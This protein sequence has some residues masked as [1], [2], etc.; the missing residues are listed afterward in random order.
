MNFLFALLSLPLL[1]P[2]CN[3]PFDSTAARQVEFWG[4]IRLEGRP[5]FEHMAVLV[6]PGLLPFGGAPYDGGHL[7]LDTKPF[8]D[9]EGPCAMPPIRP[10]ESCGFSNLAQHQHV[11]QDLSMQANHASKPPNQAATQP[12][13]HIAPCGLPCNE[14]ITT[15]PWD[16]QRE[17]EQSKQ[18]YP[19]DLT[20]RN[21]ET[22]VL[23]CRK[24]PW[25]GRN[26]QGAMWLSPTAASPATNAATSVA[27][28]GQWIPSR[29]DTLSPGDS[30][31]MGDLRPP[32]GSNCLALPA[33]TTNDSLGLNYRLAW[34]GT[35]C[36]SSGD[37][38][39]IPHGLSKATRP[40]SV[41]PFQGLPVRVPFLPLISP[42][43]H[44]AWVWTPMDWS[45]VVGAFV[46]FS[47]HRHPHARK[48]WFFC[49]IGVLIA[50]AIIW[51]L[52]TL[53]TIL[54]T[55]NHSFPQLGG[56]FGI[57]R[58]YWTSSVGCAS[59]PYA[60]T[61]LQAIHGT[62]RTGHTYPPHTRHAG[63]S[64][65]L[66]RPR[67]AMKSQESEARHEE[68]GDLAHT[69]L[70]LKCRDAQHN[71]THHLKRWG[72][73]AKITRQ[74]RRQVWNLS[75]KTNQARQSFNRL[76]D[77]SNIHRNIASAP[78]TT[79]RHRVVAAV[80]WWERAAQRGGGEEKNKHNNEYDASAVH[81]ARI[82]MQHVQQYRF[83]P[84]DCLFDSLE[85]LTGIPSLTIRQ[86]AVSHFRS[87]LA[88]GQPNAVHFAAEIMNSPHTHGLQ[89]I[90]MNTYFQ[91]MS[92]SAADGGMWADIPILTYAG[93]ATNTAIHYYR[94]RRSALD[95]TTHLET[96]PGL[97]GYGSKAPNAPHHNLL[98]TGSDL[99]GHYTPL[100]PLN[101]L[102]L[103]LGRSPLSYKAPPMAN[104]AIQSLTTTNATL[105]QHTEE[106]LLQAAKKVALSLIWGMEGS[107]DKTLTRII[108]DTLS[109]HGA[110]RIAL[111]DFPSIIV[112]MRVHLLGCQTFRAALATLD[113]P[114]IRRTGGEV[115]ADFGDDDDDDPPLPQANAPLAHV[116]RPMATGTQGTAAAAPPPHGKTAPVK[117]PTRPGHAAQPRLRPGQSGPKL[118]IAKSPPGPKRLVAPLAPAN[119]TDME[120]ETTSL[121]TPS[122][123]RED[124]CR[125]APEAAI[126][127]PPG[128]KNPPPGNLQVQTSKLKA[129]GT[130]KRLLEK[131]KAYWASW[132]T[133]SAQLEG[134]GKN[135]K[136][137]TAKAKEKHTDMGN[138]QAGTAKVHTLESAW[139]KPSPPLPTPPVTDPDLPQAAN[140]PADPAAHLAP[141]RWP[142]ALTL[143]CM[144]LLSHSSVIS[145]TLCDLLPAIAVL[146]E[147]KL[148]TQL[149]HNSTGKY[150]R[151]NILP[152]YITHFSS[153]SR[154]GVARPAGKAGVA[155]CISSTHASPGSV[156][157]INTKATYR[158]RGYVC[159]C[160][161]TRNSPY[162]QTTANIIGVYFPE[163][164][165]TRRDIYQYIESVAETC[166]K[167]G[168]PLLVAG[169]WN[170]VLLPTDR[171]GPLDAAD[172]LHAE[173]C[174]NIGL[175]PLGS[176]PSP[177]RAHTFNR[178]QL[179]TNAP[180]CTSRIDDILYL[181]DRNPPYIDAHSETV[182]E[183]GGTL[184]HLA[185]LIPIPPAI[186]SL[187]WG[188][189][190]DGHPKT[191]EG[192]KLRFPIKKEEL[193]STKDKIMAT[194]DP[195]PLR[196]AIR[197]VLDKLLEAL[198]GN[199]TSAN[200]IATRKRLQE[201]GAL[202]EVDSLANS[203]QYLLDKA[204]DIMLKTCRTKTPHSRL[205]FRNRPGRTFRRLLLETRAMKRFLAATATPR[206]V[207]NERT[208]DHFEDERKLLMKTC[209]NLTSHDQPT[210]YVGNGT[211]S[212][213]ALK[214]L[215]SE[216][217]TLLQETLHRMTDM[218]RDKDQR[219]R[220]AT[221]VAFQAKIATQRK[222]ANRTIF[223]D[224]MTD[225][226]PAAAHPEIQPLEA[227][228]DPV[229][230]KIATAPDKV[231][232]IMQEYAKCLLAPTYI[233]KDGSYLPEDRPPGF[234]YPFNDPNL[235]DNFVLDRMNAAPGAA[236][237]DTEADLLELL[238]TRGTYEDRL[239]HLGRGKM[240]G[241][242]KIPNELLKTLPDPWHDLIHDLF[243][244]MWIT[245]KTPD[246][247]KESNTILLYK[248]GDTFAPM[249]YRPIGLSNAL[250]KFWTSN[251]TYVTMHHALKNNI[252]HKCQEGGV[253]CR[254]T[255]RQLRTLINAF[256]D[257]FEHKRDLYCLYVDFSSAFNMVMHDKLLCTMYDLGIPPDAIEV[258]RDI[259]S[260]HRTTIHLPIGHTDP[261][262]LTRGT[263]Q[264]DPL[265]PLLFLLYIEPLLRWLHVGG[266]GYEFGSIPN[267]A[268]DEAGHYLKDIHNL[269]A[270]GFVDD[271]SALTGTRANMDT[272]ALK[273]EKYSAWAGTPVNASKCAV[274]AILHG[275]AAMQGGS[276]ADP[277][278][279]SRLLDHGASVHVDGRP[280]PY[281]P[282]DKPYKYLGVWLCP[283]KNWEHQISETLANITT[284]GRQLAASMASPRQCLE[285]IMT[286]IKPVITYPFCIS[287][288]T[289]QDIH[290]FDRCLAGIVRKCLRLPRSFPTASIL[291]S[292]TQGG[293]GL[294]S[295][296]VDYVADSG[297]YLVRATSDPGR[298]GHTSLALLKSQRESLGGAPV[299]EIPT[300]AA[301]YC[302]GLRQLALMA[303]NG[304]LFTING[305]PFSETPHS[306]AEHG[307]LCALLRFPGVTAPMMS[308]LHALGVRHL[309]NLVNTNGTQVITPTDLANIYGD[310]VKHRHKVA[311]NQISVALSGVS[312]DP[313][314]PAKIR[315]TETLPAQCRTLPPDLCM[316]NR[317]GGRTLIGTMNIRTLFAR[318]N[319]PSAPTHP[320][321]PPAAVV[322]AEAAHPQPEVSRR[323]RRSVK[324]QRLY[325]QNQTHSSYNTE[326]VFVS[327]ET[328]SPD[329]VSADNPG[330]LATYWQNCQA[331]AATMPTKVNSTYWQNLARNSASSW[332]DFRQAVCSPNHP[333]LPIALIAN[334]YNHQLNIT[335]VVGM[336]THRHGGRSHRNYEVSWANTMMCRHHFDACS[337]AY[338]H[339]GSITRAV[340][341]GDLDTPQ[342]VATHG[343]F[344]M[345]GTG[346]TLGPLDL[347]MVISSWSDT[348]DS[349]LHLEASHS[350]FA[351]LVTTFEG[352]IHNKPKPAAKGP[353]PP[354]DSHTNLPSHLQQGISDKL[355]SLNLP[356][357][358]TRQVRQSVHLNSRECDP[359]HD[360]TPPGQHT[361]QTGV[362]RAGESD[363][364]ASASNRENVYLPDGR[365]VGSV[366]SK[367][368]AN[369]QSM[370][371]HTKTTT[372]EVHERLGGSTFP[373]DVAQLLLRWRTRKP[374]TTAGEPPHSCGQQ[375]ARATP[376]K[377][378]A[379]LRDALGITLERFASPMDR[380][381]HSEAYWSPFP[382]DALFGS[383]HDA[384]SVPWTGA[385]QAYVGENH[386]ECEKAI[387]WAIHS[388]MSN[389]STPT[390]TILIL[391]HDPR[392]PHSRHL[393]HPATR[394]IGLLSGS[395]QPPDCQFSH[396]KSWDGRPPPDRRP[397]MPMMAMI[398]ISNPAG[399]TTFLSPSALCQLEATWA[400]LKVPE[401]IPAMDPTYMFRGPRALIRIQ[402]EASTDA[403]VV[404]RVPPPLTATHCPLPRQGP[405]PPPRP[406]TLPLCGPSPEGRGSTVVAYTD[407]SCIK[408]GITHKTGAAVYFPHIDLTIK[409]NPRGDGPSNTINRAELSALHNGIISNT[410]SEADA[411]HLYT[412]SACSISL[413]SRIIN[414][415]WSLGECIHLD[416]LRN[417]AEALRS[418]AERGQTTHVHKVRAHSGVKFNDVVDEK[419]KSAAKNPDDADVTET[420]NNTPYDS[421]PWIAHMKVDEDNA[422]AKPRLTFVSSLTI[423]TKT[424]LT[425]ALSGGGPV[426]GVYAQAWAATIPSLNP[427]SISQIWTDNHITWV[428]AIYTL[429]ARWGQLFNQKLAFRYG[430]APNPN[431]LRCGQPDSVGHMLGGCQEKSCKAITIERHNKSV[432][433]ITDTITRSSKFGGCFTVMD[434]CP[435]TQLPPGVQATRLPPWL[436]PRGH[437]AAAELTRCRPDV[438]IVEGL[439]ACLLAGKSDDQIR[440]LLKARQTSIHILEVGF[441]SDT[442]HADKESDKREQHARLLQILTQPYT[443]T[444]EATQM[445]PGNEPYTC[446]GRP[447]RRTAPFAQRA[448][449]YHPPMTIGRTGSLP[450]TL[451]E[452][453][454][455]PLQI[456]PHAANTCAAALT[457]HAVHYVERMYKNRYH[458]EGTA[459]AHAAG[460]LAE[461]G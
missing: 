141:E 203:L 110:A 79:P 108:K 427:H 194:L 41:H 193:L 46:T 214:H 129:V 57:G 20:D 408:D 410:A 260:D 4:E 42:P 402:D 54:H 450:S 438:L 28:S 454:K 3:C 63:D 24:K 10:S 378:W 73:Q 39:W 96:S 319:P 289:M 82:G 423:G 387:R 445:D 207:G 460:P 391:P 409:I 27:A 325:V 5:S 395:D 256:D 70:S 326:E 133:K 453:L 380:S 135:S 340:L 372:P 406:C 222:S 250:Y 284:K 31:R 439:P 298:L 187:P 202:P 279:L 18:L 147:T 414:A 286:C 270:L 137:N 173:Y 422:L 255:H 219:Q 111:L 241:P 158:L 377:L 456:S 321:P 230:G 451:T 359:D 352:R 114:L 248:K 371:T 238:M 143:N 165:D 300:G 411:L 92:V 176:G 113:G 307:W 434:A 126:P 458:P 106:Q 388:A 351:A 435:S 212:P 62:N 97:G 274:T 64:K 379:A 61:I 218:R 156:S 381:T 303:R 56:I 208:S 368:L 364:D 215:R 66:Q 195:Y 167:S 242:D 168:Q 90:D 373:K 285:I 349:E 186:L 125:T 153:L 431:C 237:P 315:T 52:P 196:A 17:H 312:P 217:N 142:T 26:A 93:M 261:I 302:T 426:G 432:R 67:G 192:P 421:R 123:N 205:C 177:N 1:L 384:Y 389:T 316:P 347:D 415:P 131:A 166:H 459:G 71:Q 6:G 72:Q 433:I 189:P 190:T 103:A 162:V 280:I 150:I 37:T 171:T 394:I 263:I 16:Y 272:Q 38:R 383:N 124:P 148:N 452:T 330:L 200:I 209:P 264:G 7:V 243:I 249:N 139:S 210:E 420:S 104:S 231:V 35:R 304:L 295:L 266:R 370:W 323:Q 425:A 146:T 314:N 47:L 107:T 448:V 375:P 324:A 182:V 259:Y 23:R 277:T 407:G 86:L 322:G 185:L 443:P 245:G 21:T 77:H 53:T 29:V 354:A 144:G 335:D 293:L 333:P 437:P 361:I 386:Y 365:F 84:G 419:A 436:L 152:G 428:Q 332:E 239:K 43:P 413:I 292:R 178:R 138:T 91:R 253:M 34:H 385:S 223:T 440:A 455:G 9:S 161:L 78:R 75:Q 149:H 160:T 145:E 112:S 117:G 98:F 247:W 329:K 65:P 51:T 198:D 294:I 49:M 252:I 206:E 2:L 174:S 191:P 197:V 240:V 344:I 246:R 404:N 281:Y 457:R 257:A 305:A 204:L 188:A 101:N 95:G 336:R 234:R 353:T 211:P 317:A 159:H 328:L 130:R 357:A 89:S 283:G 301:R 80:P 30:I 100:I 342:L 405:P 282:P 461:P 244:I 11:R 447:P 275:T 343:M 374:K 363:P 334:I 118:A 228:R 418:R 291:L 356:W 382:E 430:L 221:R 180:P 13:F 155:V 417:I 134:V 449:V 172:A 308:S 320:Q 122:K 358:V 136:T 424:L 376:V 339:P 163:D 442:N 8:D 22:H 268:H 399:A 350:N 288:Y 83:T 390:C 229:T 76:Y 236:N 309:G 216:A 33:I 401:D 393:Q 132:F 400:P 348:S 396:P 40:P 170:A 55:Y 313:D 154:D 69:Y 346:P 441:G 290:R 306:E 119:A 338:Q 201:D 235:P 88:Q 25:P 151:K 140:I 44:P 341:S 115:Y 59:L 297:K 14:N 12:L 36:H 318:Q 397:T 267:D 175:T 271:T 102:G 225:D 199:H 184:D 416:L 15:L 265:S 262:T 276:A 296:A 68:Y 366:A 232:E 94:L 19:K 74:Y 169:D 446:H 444:T 258:I 233:V 58:W 273:I 278:R 127:A 429:K 345:T 412:D 287:P 337:R 362:R 299:E 226:D 121:P 213:V 60:Y 220:E 311:L 85:F 50:Q 403:D 120:R 99:S 179:D 251:V 254:D 164:M 227:L 355:P 369:L 310:K 327:A 105:P 269:A 87:Q 157:R 183:P 367:C 32:V 48:L 392:A 81:L 116:A 181:K 360:I 128:G 109:P 331:F 398:A 224:P 45:I